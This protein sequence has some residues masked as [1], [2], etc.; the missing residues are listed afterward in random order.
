MNISEYGK[1]IIFQGKEKKKR[2]H[3][4]QRKQEK[5]PTEAFHFL[6]LSSFLEAKLSN[7]TMKLQNSKLI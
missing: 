4:Q 2:N 3:F 5:K 1:P 7:R 6:F